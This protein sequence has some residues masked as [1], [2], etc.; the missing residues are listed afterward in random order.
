MAGGGG[1]GGRRILLRDA[2]LLHRGSMVEMSDPVVGAVHSQW[3]PGRRGEQEEAAELA[4]VAVVAVAAVV[5]A[6]G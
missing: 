4:V 3:S 2:L 1:A 6:G 5:V